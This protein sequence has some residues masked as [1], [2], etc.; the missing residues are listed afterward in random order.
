MATGSEQHP[1][2]RTEALRRA[3]LETKERAKVDDLL[4]LEAWEADPSPGA[5]P[6]LRIGQIR[7]AN[8]ELA[9]EIRAE[10]DRRRPLTEAEREALLSDDPLRRAR[11]AAID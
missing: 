7:R 2:P 5:G 8:R 4:F 11:R 9:A 10:L 1:V 3:L 6:A